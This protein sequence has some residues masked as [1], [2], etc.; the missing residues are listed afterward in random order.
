MTAAGNFTVEVAWDSDTERRDGHQEGDPAPGYRTGALRPARRRGRPHHGRCGSR[1]LVGDEVADVPAQEGRLR[2]AGDRTAAR[3]SATCSATTTN[4][5]GLAGRPGRDRLGGFE[6]GC[7]RHRL[8]RHLRRRSCSR[9]R[10]TSRHSAAARPAARG[11]DADRHDARTSP[12]APTTRG[13]PRRSRTR[14]TARSARSQRSPRTTLE[15]ASGSTMSWDRGRRSTTS[16][17][18]WRTAS[19]SRSTTLPTEP[20]LS[21]G[22]VTVNGTVALT[23]K[24]GFLEVERAAATARQTMDD[25]RIPRRHGVRRARGRRHQAGRSRRHQDAG[26]RLT[27]DTNGSAAAATTIGDAIGVAELLFHLDDAHLDAVCNLKA[28]AGLG[29]RARASTATRARQGRR[30]G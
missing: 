15:C 24:V 20:E 29:S 12:T 4:L 9:I 10:P 7:I 18:A 8:R 3:A 25:G 22:D 17:G 19:S 28:T 26:R 2:S 14:P 13:S 16:T 30:L 1:L 23:G 27:V 5:S 11:H 21:V 6:R